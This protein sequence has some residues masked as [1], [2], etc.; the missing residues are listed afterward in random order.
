[1]RGTEEEKEKTKETEIETE[2]TTK[3]KDEE[4]VTGK[5][6]WTVMLYKYDPITKNVYREGILESRNK[7][8]E[9]QLCGRKLR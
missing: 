4:T 9:C 6:G 1:M 2:K 7:R 5:R 3:E 8:S